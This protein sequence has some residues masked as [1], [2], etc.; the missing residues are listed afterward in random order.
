MKQK[1]EIKKE[2]Y[3]PT[4]YKKGNKLIRLHDKP[5]TDKIGN[6]AIITYAD[7]IDK[8]GKEVLDYTLFVKW[9]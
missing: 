4:P 3:Y 2:P 8:K 1:K 6:K 5:F 9:L 7:F